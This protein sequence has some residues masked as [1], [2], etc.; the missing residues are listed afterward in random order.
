MSHRMCVA[1]IWDLTAYLLEV[2]L[3]YV[4]PSLV[5]QI[6]TF[7]HHSFYIYASQ[8]WIV[9]YCSWSSVLNEL[10]LCL[11]PDSST[12]SQCLRVGLKKSVR[13]KHSSESNHRVPSQL[14]PHLIP[15]T[16]RG[17][18]I[19]V[20]ENKHEQNTL[21]P[22][23]Q[24]ALPVHCS[25]SPPYFSLSVCAPLS[26]YCRLPTR[27]FFFSKF[28]GNKTAVIFMRI[29]SCPI[30]FRCLSFF[31]ISSDLPPSF[32]TPPPCILFVF[33]YIAPVPQTL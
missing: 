30:S 32:L 14:I 21:I 28:C 9:P 4:V 8:S 25:L 22:W 17:P 5:Q 18:V 1:V 2:E 19:S 13:I 31:V 24:I 6:W 3:S 20:G 12:T 10:N 27:F 23:R 15:L 16:L 26:V 7:T 33:L 11:T 29:N